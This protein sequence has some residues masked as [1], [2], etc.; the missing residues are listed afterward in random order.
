[1]ASG[2]SAITRVCTP[3]GAP[4][5]SVPVRSDIKFEVQ[6]GRRRLAHHARQ[7]RPPARF[8]CSVNA[9]CGLPATLEIAKRH[10]Q[11]MR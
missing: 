10:H 3:L 5:F 7:C 4:G 2:F 8:E 1:M 11:Q 6:H 9:D